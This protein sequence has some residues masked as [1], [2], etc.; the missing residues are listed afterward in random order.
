MSTVKIMLHLPE[1][2]R[3][4]RNISTETKL[5]T[6]KFWSETFFFTAECI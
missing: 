3:K 6:Q 2:V 5:D 4:E 1:C